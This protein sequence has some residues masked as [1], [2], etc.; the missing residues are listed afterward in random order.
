M[1]NNDTITINY[2]GHSRRYG[3]DVAESRSIL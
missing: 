3:K 2:F 1:K